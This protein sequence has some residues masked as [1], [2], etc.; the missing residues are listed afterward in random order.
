MFVWSEIKIFISRPQNSNDC[1]F[2]RIRTATTFNTN[3]ITFG[4]RL[5]FITSVNL[6]NNLHPIWKGFPLYLVLFIIHPLSAWENNTPPLENQYISRQIELYHVENSKYS[7]IS[8]WEQQVFSYITLKTASIQLYHIENSKYSAISRW[9][10]Q[11]FS[12][13]T[14]RTASIQLLFSTWYSSILAVLNVI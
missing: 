1:A 3:Y 7:A 8:R 12:Y 14:L 13:I 9:E 4:S 2:G 10:Q 11:V 5:Y 6:K